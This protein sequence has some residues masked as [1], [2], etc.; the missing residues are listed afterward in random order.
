MNQILEDKYRKCSPIFIS[1]GRISENC[2]QALLNIIT[3]TYMDMC[4][5]IPLY[6]FETSS[7]ESAI[8]AFSMFDKIAELGEIP[9]RSRRKIWLD[10]P[11][12][13]AEF[14]KKSP[15]ARKYAEMEEPNNVLLRATLC[16]ILCTSLQIFRIPYCQGMNFICGSLLINC[17]YTDSN[18]QQH[19]GG[20]V[21]GSENQLTFDVQSAICYCNILSVDSIKEMFTYS[22]ELSERLKRFQ[23]VLNNNNNASLG[24]KHLSDHGYSVHYYALEW[25]TT[26]SLFYFI[27]RILLSN[28]SV[29]VFIRSSR[30][31][32]HLKWQ[33]VCMSF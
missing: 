20:L 30:W 11:R 22:D 13:F 27:C 21:T 12:T 14:L 28:P 5:H 6:L 15:G 1:F 23:Y 3:Q 25:F 29:I 9:A 19:Q 17:Y 24:A 26:V 31:D 10:T 16:R 18:I 33:H 2:E 7:E 8:D 32:F 4:L